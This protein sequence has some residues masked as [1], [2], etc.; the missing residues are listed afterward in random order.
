MVLKSGEDVGML[1][2]DT[3]KW[4]IPHSAFLCPHVEL[5]KLFYLPFQTPRSC[6][7]LQPVSVSQHGT[8][9][10]LQG[11]SDLPPPPR[12][13]PVSSL[14]HCLLTFCACCPGHSPSPVQTW[15]SPSRGLPCREASHRRKKMIYR[16]VKHLENSF[17]LMGARVAVMPDVI[18]TLR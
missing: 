15:S 4:K 1:P 12:P 16:L 8:W 2:H 11:I 7:W 14:P 6:S 13:I 9:L 3:H 10:L 17:H 18:A 5:G